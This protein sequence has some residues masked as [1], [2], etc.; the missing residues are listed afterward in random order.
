MHVILY[1]IFHCPTCGTEDT[2]PIR[3]GH[4][5]P[6]R[7]EVLCFD[8]STFVDRVVATVRDGGRSYVSI[9]VTDV[10]G[11]VVSNFGTTTVR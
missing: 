8:H 1:R 9:P 11:H 7:S 2:E 5:R 3:S 10:Y 4:H 6:N